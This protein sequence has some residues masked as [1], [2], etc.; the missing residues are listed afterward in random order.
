MFERLDAH[1]RRRADVAV[2]LQINRMAEIPAPPG[3]RVEAMDSGV[4][5]TGKHL[6]RRLIDDPQLRNFGR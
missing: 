3:V 2:R 6:R 5:V 1:V 4:S